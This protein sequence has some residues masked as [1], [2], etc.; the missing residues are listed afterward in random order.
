MAKEKIEGTPQDTKQE[1]VFTQLDR[2][3]QATTQEEAT[4][5]INNQ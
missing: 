3:V 4:N 2:V 5:I 1:Y